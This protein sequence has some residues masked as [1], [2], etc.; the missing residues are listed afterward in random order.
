MSINEMILVYDSNTGAPIYTIDWPWSEEF[1]ES[2]EGTYLITTKDNISQL[3]VIN[4][5]VVQRQVMTQEPVISK[6]KIINDGQD[7]LTISNLAATA[8]V[9][10][11]DN[12]VRTA[13]SNGELQ[14]SSAFSGMLNIFSI[15]QFSGVYLQVECKSLSEYKEKKREE[16]KTLRNFSMR[17]TVTVPNKGTFQLAE[18]GYEHIMGYYFNA[19]DAV[20]WNETYIRGFKLLDNTWQQF[21]AEEWVLIGDT[22]EQIL[23][24]RFIH[25]EELNLAIQAATDLEGLDKIV[26]APEY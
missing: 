23:Q 18:G 15:G 5:Q 22:I 13:N 17:D 16:I 21:N 6:T 3:W 1:I 14:V 4:N 7:F 9:I 25:A 12:I 10:G 19:K 24:G 26:W 2:F 11:S 20:R 8:Q